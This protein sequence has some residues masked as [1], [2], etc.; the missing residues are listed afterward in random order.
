L[1][2]SNNA[3]KHALSQGL[4]YVTK[5]S[6]GG[7]FSSTYKANRLAHSHVDVILYSFPNSQASLHITKDSFNQDFYV[8]EKLKKTQVFFSSLILFL[9]YF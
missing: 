6:V 9:I 4:S 1:E 7:D 8:Q 5:I 3:H 2:H